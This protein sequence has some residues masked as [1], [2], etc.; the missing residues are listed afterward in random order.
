MTRSHRRWHLLLWLAIGPL[1][2][3]LLVLSL[4]WRREALP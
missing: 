3:L 2:T 1:V 4:L